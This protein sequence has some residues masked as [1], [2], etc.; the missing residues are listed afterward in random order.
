VANGVS[1][2][3]GFVL[4]IEEDLFGNETSN[5]Q[6]VNITKQAFLMITPLKQ[7]GAHKGGV[8]AAARIKALFAAPF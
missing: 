4:V 3:G 1:T 8:D 6:R 2:D 7:I 5:K